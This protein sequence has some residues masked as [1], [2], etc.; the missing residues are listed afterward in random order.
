MVAITII[1]RTIVHYSDAFELTALHAMLA[2]IIGGAAILRHYRHAALMACLAVLV[3]KVVSDVIWVGLGGE[4]TLGQFLLW[5]GILVGIL[6]CFAL[7]ATLFFGL[8][9]AGRALRIVWWVSAGLFLLLF[10]WLTTLLGT[11]TISAR[12]EPSMWF[13]VGM[14]I[15]WAFGATRCKPMS[16]WGTVLLTCSPKTG[17]PVVRVFGRLYS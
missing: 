7:I 11:G 5:N 4:Q 15:A 16:K 9:R 1:R 3:P 14:G 6:S 2:A 10:A 12:Q 8:N 17:P 13:L